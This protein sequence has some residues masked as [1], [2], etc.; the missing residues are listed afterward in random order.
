MIIRL[1]NKLLGLVQV[2]EGFIEE[3]DKE[4]CKVF[5]HILK[6]R[7]RFDRLRLTNNSI[8]KYLTSSSC[9]P[10]SVLKRMEG[11]TGLWQCNMG[12]LPWKPPKCVC[13]S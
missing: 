9:L 1:Y 11:Q 12:V 10:F 8:S 7:G 3:E 5:H 6:K 2:N 4:S 13:L